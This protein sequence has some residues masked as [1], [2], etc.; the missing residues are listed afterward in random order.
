M[1]REKIF[2]LARDFF[3]S[4]AK[5]KK[6][7]RVFCRKM[8]PLFLLFTLV[9]FVPCFGCAEYLPNASLKA[10]RGT[11]WR[12]LATPHPDYR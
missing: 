3:H 2:L 5:A 1:W 8:E 11:K 6:K 12:I 9:I 7:S 10:I 4:R